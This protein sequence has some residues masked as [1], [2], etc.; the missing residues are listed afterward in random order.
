MSA[1]YSDA[2][3]TIGEDLELRGIKTFIIRC[4]ADLFVVEAGYQSPPAQTPVTL[5]YAA[6]DL[7]HLAQKARER[8]DHL[9]SVKDFLSLSK[10]LWAVATYVTA[11]EA[12]LLRVSNNEGT[13][14]M[15]A[16]K[17]EYET[18][19]GDR[20]V[21][22][23]TGSAIYQLCVSIYKL[24]TTSSTKNGRYTRFS[25]LQEGFNTTHS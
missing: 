20:L 22:D 12:R 4:E 21:E 9:S 3:R 16:V 13:G 24:R 10:I 5:H 6:N 23:L 19:R 7:E 25:A 2:L 1:N 15:P 17:F 18:F 11:K 14:R 8:N